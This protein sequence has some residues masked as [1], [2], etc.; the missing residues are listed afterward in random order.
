MKRGNFRRLLSLAAACLC[1]GLSGC[2]GA[3]SAQT[4]WLEEETAGI[5]PE[6]NGELSYEVRRI[7]ALDE[8]SVPE[9]L[10][11][12]TVQWSYDDDSRLVRLLYN[13]ENYSLQ[14]RREDYR[15]GFYDT[16]R[17]QQG[18]I[19]GSSLSPGGRYWVFDLVKPHTGETSRYTADLSAAELPLR[20]MESEEEFLPCWG[21]FWSRDGLRWAR[22]PAAPFAPVLVEDSQTGEET[23]RW[24]DVSLPYLEEFWSLGMEPFFRYYGGE[25]SEDGRFC[26]FWAIDQ[27]EESERSDNYLL[28]G[29]AGGEPYQWTPSLEE[30]IRSAVFCSYQDSQAVLFT[31]PGMI[32]LI[33]GLEEGDPQVQRLRAVTR[34]RN[35]AVTAD[36]SAVAYLRETGGDKAD[37]YLCRFREGKLTEEKLVYR[38]ID[39]T[40]VLSFNANGKCL[41]LEYLSYESGPYLWD[42]DQAV[43]D[44]EDY[45]ENDKEDRISGGYISHSLVIEFE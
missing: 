31:T 13:K 11:G 39:S 6:E 25:V 41:L 1:A 29:T 35:L 33:T 37:V 12:P 27:M 38:G 43:D 23:G 2:S 20:E 9:R 15:F 22:I 40:A 3:E 19:C 18:F 5:S 34:P 8:G 17:Y 21:L 28:L 36:G 45:K 16:I 14:L 10:A 24:E 4:Y 42:E 7:Y 44:G 30:P 32:G 26:H